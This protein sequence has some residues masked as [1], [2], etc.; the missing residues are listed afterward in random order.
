MHR[1]VLVQPYIIGKL[2]HAQILPDKTRPPSMM[3]HQGGTLKL[4]QRAGPIPAFAQLLA[5][6]ML[7]YMKP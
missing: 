5:V 1:H 2:M 7:M 3:L 4:L 6:H